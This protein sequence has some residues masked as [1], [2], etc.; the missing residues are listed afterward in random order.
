MTYRIFLGGHF[1]QK[2]EGRVYRR[3]RDPEIVSEVQ[4]GKG[5]V[6]FLGSDKVAE[7]NPSSLAIDWVGK[8]EGCDF[9]LAAK[10]GTSAE[11]ERKLQAGRNVYAVTSNLNWLA[12]FAQQNGWNLDVRRVSGS[13]EAYGE[14]ADMIAD[15]RVTGDTLRD[16]GLEEFKILDAVRLGIIYRAVPSVQLVNGSE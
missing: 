9:V 11:V 3:L 12:S 14:E 2:S 13:A 1:I 15:L 8:V 6:G 7:W 5:D 4:R 16:N 10:Q